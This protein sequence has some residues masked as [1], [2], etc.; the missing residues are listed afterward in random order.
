M[1]YH[2]YLLQILEIMQLRFLAI[3]IFIFL[4]QG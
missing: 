2:W 3:M 4:L 1:H